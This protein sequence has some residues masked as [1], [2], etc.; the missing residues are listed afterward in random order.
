[1]A[2]RRDLAEAGICFGIFDL[3]IPF[4][5]QLESKVLKSKSENGFTKHL[6]GSNNSPPS[7]PITPTLLRLPF[8]L[9][10]PEI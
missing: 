10:S 7:T 3:D 6:N 5:A 8:S 1:M 9:I 2:V 4:Y